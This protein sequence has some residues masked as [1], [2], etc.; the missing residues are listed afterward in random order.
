MNSN[1]SFTK[2]ALLIKNSLLSFGSR[3]VPLVIG[4]IAIPFLI[5]LLGITRFGILTLAW[6]FIGYSNIFD[7]GLSRAGIKFISNSIGDEKRNEIPLIFWTLITVLLSIGVLFAIIL[8]S[9]SSHLLTF[10]LEANNDL[11]NEVL[12]LIRVVAI[13]LPV[14]LL[15]SGLNAYLTAFQS[16]KWISSI[17][18]T[19]GILNYT[20]PVLIL[21]FYEGLI[22]V[23]LTL[24]FVKILILGL[25]A[26]SVKLTSKGQL[27]SPIFSFEHM[28]E[29]LTYGGWVSVSNVLSPLIDYIDRFYIAFLIGA[30]VVAFFTTPMDVLLKLGIIPVSVVVVLFPAVSS[31][32]RSN[33]DKA[34]RFTTTG[35]N[36]T[37]ILLFPIVAVLVLF[38][39]ELLNLWIGSEFAENSTLVAQILLIGIFLKSFTNYSVTYLHGIGKPKQTALVHIGEAM[40]YVFVLYFAVREF[41]LI[42]AAVIH[43]LR[44]SADF[45][46]MKMLVYREGHK[47]KRSILKSVSVISLCALLLIGLFFIDAIIIKIFISIFLLPASIIISWNTLIDEEVK[48]TLFNQIPGSL[49]KK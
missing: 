25:Y 4:I 31:L 10:I 3:T 34:I 21:L 2:A 22:P 8:F 37:L 28:K 27:G 26:F 6:V 35:I 47:L 14:V 5:D 48:Q 15:I 11:E 46:L 43:S 29:L 19:S 7:F 20:A 30:G 23:M 38:A 13:T 49:L 16:F 12:Y 36:L 40:I 18:V 42:G 41:E 45:F 17:Q 1:T 24:F 33:R 9:T 39:E 32:S 44:L